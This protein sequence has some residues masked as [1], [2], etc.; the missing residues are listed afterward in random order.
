MSLLM[1]RRHRRGLMRGCVETAPRA[2]LLARLHAMISGQLRNSELVYIKDRAA[3]TDLISCLTK[4]RTRR[5]KQ[6][7]LSVQ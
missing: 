7:C 4:V 3:T 1:Y 5:K 6:T 2:C